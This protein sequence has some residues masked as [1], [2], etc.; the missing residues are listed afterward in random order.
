MSDKT[1]KDNEN[2]TTDTSAE[3]DSEPSEMGDGG[4]FSGDIP[5]FMIIKKIYKLKERV[6]KLEGMMK[7][8]LHTQSG[9]GYQGGGHMNG[10]SCDCECSY[11][12]R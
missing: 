1:D 10:C 12:S 4:W 5:N 7:V 2:Q 3:M 8:M 6:A 9:M 11:C